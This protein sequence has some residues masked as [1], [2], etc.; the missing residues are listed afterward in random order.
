MAQSLKAAAEGL[1]ERTW[2]ALVFV[3]AVSL[4]KEFPQPHKGQRMGP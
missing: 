3:F 4:A 2:G 1:V